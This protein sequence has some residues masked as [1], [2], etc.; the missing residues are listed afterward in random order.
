MKTQ[1]DL[2]GRFKV[3]RDDLYPGGTKARILDKILA[4]VPQKEIIYAGHAYGYAALALAAACHRHGKSVTVFLPKTEGTPSP[5]R[6]ALK[7][8]NIKFIE[9][10]EITSQIDLQPCVDQYRNLNPL[11]RASFP[12]GFG[13]EDFEKHLTNYIKSIPL[14]PEEVWALAGSGCL[15][16][17]LQNAW[18]ETTVNAVSMGFPQLNAGKA[19]IFDIEEEAEQKAK[20]PPPYP[21]AEY[22]DAKI[23]R[24]ADQH[25]ADGALIWNV[26]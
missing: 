23:W 3:L 18:P 14:I 17:C 6:A 16:R 9:K 1:I 11:D 2:V 7:Y 15:V 12:I 19:K 13:S 10:P 24:I 26:A 8:P 21:S 5:L 22:Y 25:G 20:T 4:D